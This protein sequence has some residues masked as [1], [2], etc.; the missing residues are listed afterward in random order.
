MISIM[1]FRR[2]SRGRSM[3]MRPVIQ[4]FKKVLNFAPTSRLSA[5]EHPSV[6][7]VGVDSAAAGQTGPTDANVPTGSVIKFIEI[8]WS[9]GN[10]SGGNNF[11]TTSI[12]KLHSGQAIIRSDLVGGDPQRNQIHNQTSFQIGTDQNGSRKYLFKI[13]K[14]FQRVRDGDSW[15][16]TRRGSATFTDAVQVI[17]KF[18]R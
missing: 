13:P 12:Q 5:V 6:L 8:Q 10:L 14:R 18:Y 4:S 1:P 2:R 9:M 11:F 15:V 7:S 16:F 3:G 17:Y